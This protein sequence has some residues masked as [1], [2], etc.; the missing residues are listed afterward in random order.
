MP[1]RYQQLNYSTTEFKLPPP[2]QIKNPCRIINFLILKKKTKNLERVIGLS[3]ETLNA[4]NILQVS[5]IFPYVV[6]CSQENA[7][8]IQNSPS[9]LFSSTRKRKRERTKCTEL[10]VPALFFSFRETRYSRQ[11]LRGRVGYRQ[12][13]VKSP[14]EPALSKENYFIYFEKKNT[15][16]KARLFSYSASRTVK[17]QNELVSKSRN[18][19]L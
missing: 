4:H 17:S 9:R 8:R 10:K 15:M 6:R 16:V 7:V 14:N 18:I 11:Q 2:L 3:W 13:Q 19:E 1:Q 5:T 12:L